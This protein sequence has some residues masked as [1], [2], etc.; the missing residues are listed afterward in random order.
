VTTGA[1]GLATGRGQDETLRVGRGWTTATG[2]LAAAMAASGVLIVTLG[3]RLTFFLDDWVF[4]LYRRSFNADAFFGPDNEHL[5]AG[6]VAVWQFLLNT[7]GMGSTVPFRIVST[8]AFLLG[9]W[10]LFVWIRRR[11]GEWPALLATVPILFLGAAYDDLLWFSSITFLGAMAF[12]LGMLVALDRR[13]SLGDALAC[14]ALVGSMLFSSLWLAFAVGVVVDVA[15]RRDERDWRRRAYVVVAPV[16]LYAIWWL[17]WGQDGE[18][19]VSLHN[20]ATTP[21]FVLNSFAA[22]LGALFGLATQVEGTSA[23]PGLDWGRPLAVFLGALAAWRLYKLDRVPRSLWVVL[24]I[25]LAFWVFGGIAVKPGRVAWA[26]RYQ[27]PSVAFVLLVAA[28][29]LRGARLDRRLLVPALIVVAASV[30]SNGLVLDQSYRSYHATTQLERADLA[31]LEIAR[32]TVEPNFFIDEENGDTGY[33]HVDAGSYLNARDAYGSPAYSLDELLASPE[34]ARFAAD[35]VLVSALG[36]GLAP[37][38]ASEFPVQGAEAGE[39]NSEG[40]VPI[41]AGAC[42]TVEAGPESPLLALPPDGAAIV[43]GAEPVTDIKM[44]RF[45]SEEFSV[46]FQ[47]GIEPGQAVALR[48]PPDA[49]PTVP[50]KL[51][52]EGSEATAC[53]LGP[54][55]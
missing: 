55:A 32:D 50:W 34:P 13:D 17:G 42:L 40:V 10:F 12:G 8:A 7:F 43:A 16:V 46:D 18:S 33:V 11:L 29:L 22:A 15:L 51:Q 53:G 36:F 30:A 38:N 3:S 28:E 26:S 4:I 2:L 25:G 21:L 37:A 48:L 31:A 35:K 6:P 45:A 19:S 14:A 49:A 24:A 41:P 23:P 54:E 20:L 1:E 5:V 39:A 44:R 9:A 52:L 47:E 27:Y